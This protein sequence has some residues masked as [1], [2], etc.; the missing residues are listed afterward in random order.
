MRLDAHTRSRAARAAS[1][2]GRSCSHVEDLPADLVDLVID[3]AEGNPFYIEELVTWLM[4]AGVVVRGEPHWFVVDELIRTVAV[5]STLKG[6]L[7]SRLDALSIEER[8][9]LQRASVVGRVFWDLAVAHL[10]D[11]EHEVDPAASFDSLRR[12]EVCCSGRSPTSPP[13]GSSCSSTPCCATSPTTAS[14]APTASAT[15]GGAAAWLAETSAAVG[16]QDEYAA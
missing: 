2:C 8:D 11:R 13:P 12:R 5:P 9:L 14:C 16:R 10:D 1:W 15:T 3:S 4:D 6:V 7:Q